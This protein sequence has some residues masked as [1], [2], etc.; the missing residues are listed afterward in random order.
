M[1]SVLTGNVPVKILDDPTKLPMSFS[2]A[3]YPR[4]AV[5]LKLRGICIRFPSAVTS[6][7]VSRVLRAITGKKVKNYLSRGKKSEN[8]RKRKWSIFGPCRRIET[9]CAPPLPLSPPRL[10]LPRLSSSPPS[11]TAS[12][13]MSR[14][15][16]DASRLSANMVYTRTFTA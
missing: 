10:P 14:G 9:D 1:S 12:E 6:V 13:Q 11:S 2:C 7:A 15:G 16:Q 4:R 8:V 3:V 5:T